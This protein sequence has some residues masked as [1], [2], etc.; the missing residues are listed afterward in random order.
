MASTLSCS[1]QTIRKLAQCSRLSYSLPSISFKLRLLLKPPLREKI[2]QLRELLDSEGV[3]GVTAG[4]VS[5]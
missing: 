4:V 3:R 1:N 2:L 5:K